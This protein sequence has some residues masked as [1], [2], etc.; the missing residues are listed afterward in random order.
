LFVRQSDKSEGDIS[1]SLSAY[2]GD[3]NTP[4]L[5]NPH[6]RG[7]LGRHGNA[8]RTHARWSDR[9][10]EWAKCAS[11]WL[12]VFSAYEQHGGSSYRSG[13]L[14]KSLPTAKGVHNSRDGWP[15]HTAID[16]QERRYQ[17]EGSSRSQARMSLVNWEKLLG[18][19]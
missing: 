17:M 4:G 1:I 11:H 6:H 10:R 15:S 19:P 9:R 18:Y 14:S 12:Q 16:G 8:M 2:E 3:G 5:C 13:S 7:I